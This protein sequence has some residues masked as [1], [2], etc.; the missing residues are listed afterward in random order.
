MKI[1]W[2]MVPDKC[3]VTDIFF[4]ILTHFLLF[5]PLTTQKIKTLKNWKTWIYHHFT[6]AYLKWDHMMYSS[7]DEK[8]DRQNFCC[9]FGSLLPS[10]PTNTQKN[11][12]F[13]KMKKFLEISSF[14]TNVPTIMTISYTV[15]KIWRMA[16]VIFIFRFGLFFSLI[17]SSSPKNQNLRKW[18]KLEVS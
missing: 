16:D 10:Y 9:C 3:S 2:G 7:W 1:I 15:L 14:Y 5:Y 11:L 8:P 18:K 13:Q 17:P 12:N 6:Q 4:L